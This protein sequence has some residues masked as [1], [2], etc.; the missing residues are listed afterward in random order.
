M[1]G[2]TLYILHIVHVG[3]QRTRLFDQEARRYIFVLNLL[4][5]VT[6]HLHI[7]T[8]TRAPRARARLAF[9]SF[10]RELGD[11][12]DW[13][14]VTIHL[15]GG[16]V[17]KM[18]DVCNVRSVSNRIPVRSQVFFGFDRTAPILLLVADGEPESEFEPE[19]KLATTTSSWQ[20]VR[21][22]C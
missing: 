10:P 20:V 19:G 22:A 11:G 6:F 16:R 5:T 18:H 9:L 7:C 15:S 2:A 1:Y 13:E 12:Q 3:C 21:A 4:T 17:L 8:Y 14:G